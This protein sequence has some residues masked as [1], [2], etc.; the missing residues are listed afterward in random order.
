MQAVIMA[1]GFGTRLRPIT[2]NIPKPMA[3]VAG[4]PILRH[5]INLLKKHKFLDLTMMLYY[6]P[7]IITDYFGDGKNFGVNIKYLRPE[8]DLGTAGSVKFAGKNIKS[9]FLAISGDVLIDIDLLKAVEFHK[10]KKALAAIVLTRV[11]N[12]LQF[13]VVITNKTGKIERFL[14]KPSWGEVFSDTINT[15]IYILE[16]EI[17]KY[18]PENEFFDFSKDLYPLFLREKK[19]LYGCIADGYWKDVGNHDEYRTVHYDILDGQVILGDN[20]TVEDCAVISR[21]VIG[22]GSKI[23]VG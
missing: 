2:C 17:F 19:E 14:E 20:V 22:S 13:G 8:L 4:K 5:T 1:G 15:G 23:G 10:K 11:K 16:P 21:S 12:P 7:E 18:I 6:Q 9:A 3:P